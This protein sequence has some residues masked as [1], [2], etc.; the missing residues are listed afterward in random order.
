MLGLKYLSQPYTKT[1][2]LFTEDGEPKQIEMFSREEVIA[3]LQQDNVCVVK[4][5][6]S[7]TESSNACDVGDFFR[8]PKTRLKSINDRDVSVDMVNELKDIIR[9]HHIRLNTPI[10]PIHLNSAACGLLRIQ[11]AQQNT[12]KQS[13]IRNAFQL[14]G[15]YDQKLGGVNVDTLL[16]NCTVKPTQVQLNAIKAC[17]PHLGNVSLEFGEI[18][19]DEFDRC[20]IARTPEDANRDD[21]VIYRRRTVT[22]TNAQ[23]VLKE[24]EKRDKAAADAAAKAQLKILVA[25]R[26]KLKKQ[27]QQQEAEIRKRQLEELVQ[28]VDDTV[29]LVLKLPRRSTA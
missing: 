17:L 29:P 13:I 14:T 24:K 2:S 6:A 9:A 1:T 19:E 27:I 21:L 5:P 23:V 7:T 10:N 3:K 16:G 20:G 25:N 4:P 8:G 26:A 18:P 15:I 12:L 28:G 22:L 11:M